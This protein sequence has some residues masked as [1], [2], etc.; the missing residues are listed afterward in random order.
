MKKHLF[1]LPAPTWISEEQRKMVLFAHN[2]N[3]G[4][5]PVSDEVSCWI[6]S[7]RSFIIYLECILL[8]KCAN[9]VKLSIDDKHSFT[10]IIEI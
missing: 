3:Q 6:L 1:Q 9:L 10:M 5:V 4:V 8:F 2:N 7:L